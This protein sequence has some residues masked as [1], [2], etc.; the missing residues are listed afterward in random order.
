MEVDPISSTWSPLSPP[1]DHHRLLLRHPSFISCHG[2]L[3]QPSS[4]VRGRLSPPSLYV[5]SMEAKGD[6]VFVVEESSSIYEEVRMQRETWRDMVVCDGG[7]GRKIVVA[8]RGR[9]RLTVM[10]VPTAGLA[11]AEGG[12]GRGG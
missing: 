8:S 12:P 11:A 7:G 9:G 3:L 10:D 2:S 1:P 6:S 5:A 4:L